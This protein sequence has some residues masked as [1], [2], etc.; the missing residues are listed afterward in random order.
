[1]G[2]GELGEGIEA[3]QIEWAVDLIADCKEYGVPYFL[4]QLGCSV[5]RSGKKL[6]FTDHH[7]GDWSEWPRQLRVRQMPTI[8]KM[9]C[10][11]ARSGNL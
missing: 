11:D 8:S 10:C 9:A 5:Y 4:K 2:I 7:A 6:S 1:M 3:F